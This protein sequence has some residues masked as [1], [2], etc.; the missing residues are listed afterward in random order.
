MA[1]GFTEFEGRQSLHFGKIIIIDTQVK[2]LNPSSRKLLR[3]T[4]VEAGGD[5][6]CYPSETSGT[7]LQPQRWARE[8]EDNCNI[9][10][11]S[12]NTAFERFECSICF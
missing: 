9:F 10:Y 5:N 11:P 8:P 12:L 3:V 4:E 2:I 1:P 7:L 6:K